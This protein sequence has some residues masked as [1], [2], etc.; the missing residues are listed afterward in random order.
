MVLV[1]DIGNTNIVIG[2]FSENMWKHIWRIET[3]KMKMSS[4]IAY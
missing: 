1:C 3:K 2:I 4:I